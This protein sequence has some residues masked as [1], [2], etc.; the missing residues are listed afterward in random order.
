MSFL[1]IADHS[2]QVILGERM[3][4]SPQFAQFIGP[5][6]GPNFFVE[7]FAISI[8]VGIFSSFLR[9]IGCRI[10]KLLGLKTWRKAERFAGDNLRTIHF[11]TNC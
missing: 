7:L 4:Q 3:S 10:G 2:Y 9:W 6:D 1:G 11:L 8:V 5:K